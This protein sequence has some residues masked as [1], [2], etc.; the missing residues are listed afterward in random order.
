[1]QSVLSILCGAQFAVLLELRGAGV[2]AKQVVAETVVDE[3]SRDA[4]V[5]K[6]YRVDS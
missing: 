3:R 4:G 2:E 1:M 6:L 5:Y